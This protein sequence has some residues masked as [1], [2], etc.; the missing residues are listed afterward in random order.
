M[1]L[2]DKL[3]P[4]PRWKHADPAVRLAAIRDLTDPAELA[5][6]A[7]ADTDPRVRRAAIVQLHDPVVIGRVASAD[8]DEETRERAADRLVAIAMNGG[9]PDMAL[10]AVAHLSDPR[11]LSTIA[12]SDITEAVC[13]SALGRLAD[14]RAL[15]SLARQARHESIARAALDRVAGDTELLD[16]A[17]NSQHKDVALSAFERVITPATDVAALRSIETRAQQKAVSRRARAIVAEREAAEAA[18]RTAEDERRR[19]AAALCDSVEQLS[20]LAADVALLRAELSRVSDAWAALGASDPAAQERF[21]RGVTEAQATIARRER[22]AEEAAEQARQRAENIATRTALCAR[23]ETLD[24]EN[25]DRACLEAQ[26][27]AIEQ[28]WRSLMPL[29]GSGPEADRLAERFAQAVAACR[30][31]HERRALLADARARLGALVEEAEGLPSQDETASARWQTLAR[32]ARGLTATLSEAGQP[33]DDLSARLSAVEQAFGDRDRI[34]RETEAKAQEE[35]VTHLRRL[36]ERARRVADADTITLR[37]GDRLMRDISTSLD[38]VTRLPSARLSRDIED[39]AAAVRAAQEKVA[40]RLRELREMD[41]WRRFANA[42]R[43]EQLIAMAEAI[44]GSL[45]ADEEASRPSDLP[46]TAR[47]L[48]ELH[49]KWQEAA[50]APRHSAQKL[51]DRFRTSTDFIRSRCETYFSKLREERHTNQQQ[52]VVI[53]EEAESLAQSSDWVKTAARFQELQAAWQHIGPVPRD[54]A[55]DLAQRFRTACND[56][57]TRRRE[58]LAGRKKVWTDNL[59]QKEALCAR[60]EA[61]AESTDWA[62]AS[63]EIKR[64]QAEWKT[65]GPVRRSKS[66]EVWNRFR[67]ACDKFFERYHNRH[68][69]TFASKLAEREALVVELE[70]LLAAEGEAPEGLAEK[71][72]QVR[73]TWNRS[74]PIPAAEVQ[75]LVDRWHAA[76]A[77]ILERWPAAFAGTDLDPAAIVQKM[78]RLVT[79]IESYLAEVRDQTAGLSQAEILAARLRS[80]LA[81]NAMGGRGADDAKWRAAGD[82]VKDAQASWQR[83]VPIATPEAH[84]LETR[85]RDACRRVLDQVRRHSAPKQ[86]SSRPHAHAS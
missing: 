30:I 32:E 14:D 17:L 4:V 39:A 74:V 54:A 41:D 28:E 46:A 10:A 13:A 12:R 56:F 37:E 71:V 68:Q 43:Q 52:R 49:T 36:A 83:L 69:I 62:A 34:R 81:T 9:G 1:G 51:W 3:K 58:D 35:I 21:A 2:L 25:L 53:V 23:V 57:F 16:V 31:R 5:A 38:N 24:V 7:E 40:P 50:E 65:I 18:R 61:L 19:Q 86:R 59:T 11:R 66:E 44:V 55:R 60:A 26:L 42:Q 76:F 67:A 82:A 20:T 48:R 45:K 47:A 6:V 85:F 73:T 22:E 27:D 75:P 70:G 29:V 84:A 33:V 79:K 15:G 64:M 80:A 8:A 78:D 63:A 77:R 72:Q